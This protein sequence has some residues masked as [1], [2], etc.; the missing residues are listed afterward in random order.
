MRSAL[1]RC[2]EAQLLR[3][4]TMKTEYACIRIVD[5]AELIRSALCHSVVKKLGNLDYL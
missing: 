5:R 4:A 1:S 3:L 2:H